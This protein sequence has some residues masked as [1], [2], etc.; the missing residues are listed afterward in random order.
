MKA[1]SN[2][3][4]VRRGQAVKGPFQTTVIQDHL[5]LGR[6]RAEDELS[7]DKRTW[8]II[9]DINEFSAYVVTEEERN[10]PEIQE[11]IRRID[12]RK[13]SRSTEDKKEA[14]NE[15]SRLDGNSESEHANME[16]ERLKARERRQ[17]ESDDILEY[18]AQ[19]AEVMDSLKKGTKKTACNNSSFGRSVNNYCVGICRNKLSG[20]RRTDCF[21]MH[22]CSCTRC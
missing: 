14:N 18:R 19:R 5:L 4:F 16:S 10:T 11:K 15:H 3:W 9:N 7:Q 12:E 8:Q 13:A 6:L 2:Q 17:H 1:K 22:C 21:R 20:K